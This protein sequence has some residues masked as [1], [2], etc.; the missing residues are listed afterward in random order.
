MHETGKMLVQGM[1]EDLID[2]LTSKSQTGL[3]LVTTGAGYVMMDQRQYDAIVMLAHTL[4]LTFNQ[5]F[6]EQQ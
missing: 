6:Q 1:I 3:V 5:S 2:R 4:S